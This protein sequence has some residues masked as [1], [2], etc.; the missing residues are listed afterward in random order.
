MKSISGTLTPKTSAVVPRTI[1]TL[2]LSSVTNCKTSVA[3]LVLDQF[4]C[5][6]EVSLITVGINAHYT[7]MFVEPCAC[8]K[9]TVYLD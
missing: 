2:L 1:R 9:H 4:I 5:I 8:I 7:G 3:S 6:T